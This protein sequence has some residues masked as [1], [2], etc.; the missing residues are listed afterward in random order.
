VSDKVLLGPDG[1]AIA[2]RKIV[3][4]GAALVTI[5]RDQQSGT[6]VRPE[7]GNLLVEQLFVQGSDDGLIEI[8]MDHR[9][10]R[11]RQ[12]IGGPLQRGQGI[13][14]MAFR[15]GASLGFRLGP[16]DRILTSAHDGARVDRRLGGNLRWWSPVTR[17]D[18]DGET[19]GEYCSTHMSSSP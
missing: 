17:P 12:V 9:G 3:F 4:F 7:D 14:S 19:D 5:S 13:G 10:E 15:H 8:E 6:R 11:R 2:Q 18:T 1:A 16:G